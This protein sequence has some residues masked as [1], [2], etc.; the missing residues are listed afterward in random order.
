MDLFRSKQTVAVLVVAAVGTLAAPTLVAAQTK[1]EIPHSFP[2]THRIGVEGF[3]TIGMSWPVATKSFEA[4]G[5]DTRPVEFGGGLQ[6]T[7]VWRDLFSQ[8]SASRTSSTGERVF[9]DDSGNLFP[10]GIPL[11]VKATYIDISVGW[12]FGQTQRA[13][14]PYA[15]GGAGMVTYAE[16]SPFAQPDDDFKASS[17]SY[18]LLGGVEIRLLKWLGVSADVRYRYVPDVLGKG[19]V[20]AAFGEDDLGGAQAGV[21]MRILFGGA[22]RVPTPSSELPES[23]AKI[24]QDDQ[25]PL[26]QPELS[27]AGVI[28]EQAPVFLLPDATRTPLRTL[29]PGTSVRILSADVD[30]VR[31]EFD[32]RLLGPRIGYV[33][34]KHIRLPK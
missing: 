10:L 11:S 7:N 34:R 19:G 8:V 28:V 9:V 14:V 6:I 16:E 20:S 21:G 25:T 22:T 15:G 30:W 29:E 4:T 26:V 17:P 1:A 2:S 24:L 27:N 18:H 23:T 13:V 5:L 33:Q 12:K 32:D 3:G 31:I